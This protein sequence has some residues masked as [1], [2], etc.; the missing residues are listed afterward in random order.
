VGRTWRLNANAS[1]FNGYGEYR[2]QSADQ[3]GQVYL[4]LA[5]LTVPDASSKSQIE[6]LLQTAPDRIPAVDVVVDD[7]EVTGKKVGRFEILAVN[8]RSPGLLGTGTAQEWRVQKLNITNP[9][10]T[11]KAT[12]VWLPSSDAGSERGNKRHVDVQ[13]NLDVADSGALMTRFGLPGTIKAGKGSLQGRAAWV[14]SPWAVNIPTLSGQLKMDM[15]KGQFLK[16]EPG[17]AGRFFNVLSLQALPRLLTLDFRDVF[18]DGFAFD[19]LSGDAQ[20]NEGVLA[21]TNLQM[22]SVLA[23]VSMDGSV[24]LAK[25]TQNLHVLVL[26]DI[27]AGGVSLLATLINPVVGAVTYLAQLVLRRPVIAAATKEYSIQGSWIEPKIT[28][29]KRGLPLPAP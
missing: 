22:K 3:A 10:A 25:E 27:N 15:S 4:R 23:L 8:Q 29:L 2:P 7:F 14:G 17:R 26:P 18:S 24:D 5:K 12:G 9:D 6:Q 28:P 13:F 11:L 20:I 21:S 19:N 16:I 1:D